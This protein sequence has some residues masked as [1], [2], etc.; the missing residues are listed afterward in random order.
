MSGAPIQDYYL[1]LTSQYGTLNCNV[2]SAG[3]YYKVTGLS[4][5]ETYFTTI[6]ASNANGLGTVAS[7]R[8]FQP[9]SPPPRGVSSLSAVAITVSTGAALV[10]W[11]PPIGY[12]PV[13]DATIFWYAIYGYTT[14][15]ALTPVVK[16]TAGGQTQSNYFIP[17]LDSNS[18]YYFTVRAVNCPGWSVPLLTN[19]I[20]WVTVPA[21][22]PTMASGL[23]LWLDASDATTIGLVGGSSSNINTWSD[24][25]SNN[26]AASTPA[27]KPYLNFSNLNSLNTI[28]TSN[29]SGSPNF[30]YF[31]VNNNY[32]TTFLTYVIVARVYAGGGGSSYGMI[33]TD[34]PGQYGRGIGF[35]GS[36]SSYNYQ[37]LSEN[38]FTTTTAPTPLGSWTVLSIVFNNTTTSPFNVNGSNYS[39]S[40]GNTAPNNTTGLKI[41]IW[42][43]DS[44]ILNTSMEI[45]ETTVYTSA[46][47]PFNTQKVEGYL[48]WKWGL[49]SNLPTIHPF[50]SSRPMSNSV[51]APPML[52][53]LRLWLDASD[54]STLTGLSTVSAWADKSGNSNN[55]SQAV[56]AQQ[57]V[58][59]ITGNGLTGLSFTTP[60]TASGNDAGGQWFRGTFGTTIT[61]NILSVFMVGSMNSGAQN[62][63]R[64]VS[65]SQ[66][67]Q[68]DFVTGG[69]GM[70]IG[71]NGT[72]NAL[73]M[74]A[75]GAY[76]AASAVTL[77]VPFIAETVFDGANQIQVVNGTQTNTR[78]F[79]AN[80]N[81]ARSGIGF[82]A[83]QGVGSTTGRWDG[84]INEV[85]VYNRALSTQDRQTV[86]GY[87]AWKY[88]LQGN[89]PIT[90][91]YKYSNPSIVNFTQISPS[92]FGGLQLWLDASQLT[93]LSNGGALTT[94][95]DRTSNAFVGTAVASPTFI[96]N[97]MNDLPV[98][99]FNGT[100]Q[101][102]NFG[103]N[104]LNIGSNSGVATFAVIKFN[105]T[106]AGGVVG[107]TVY[108]P[109]NARWALRR[110][111]N[112]MRFLVDVNGTGTEATYSDTTTTT[113]LAEGVW[114]R[115]Q[116]FIYKNG[117]L[118]GSNTQAS[119]SNLSNSAPLWVG[120]YPNGSGS[121][122]QAGLFMNG[123]V[124]EI[125]VYMSNITPFIRQ[126]IEGYLSWKWGLQAS[127]PT[128]HPY[129]TAPP[130][131]AYTTFN[132]LLLPNLQLWLDASDT[133]T[134]SFSSGSNIS[135]WRDKSGRSNNA[136][137]TAGTVRLAND[138]NYTAVV[139]TTNATAPNSNY[140]TTSVSSLYTGT[141]TICVAVLRTSSTAF[142][143]AM[144][145]G[146]R[147]ITYLLNTAIM[148]IQGGPSPAASD[149]GGQLGGNS[150]NVNGSRNAMTTTTLTS[151]HIVSFTFVPDATTMSIGANTNGGSPF[152][153]Y[154]AE[155]I[156]FNPNTNS[157]TPYT[158]QRQTVEGYLA[159]KWGLQGLLPATHPY[160]SVNPGA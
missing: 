123:D 13:P 114:N 14:A 19:T 81:I 11:T 157:G 33:A 6:A 132:P 84:T 28:N 32:N 15:N 5:A 29:F 50:R 139:D 110:E 87:L 16:Y 100:S 97:S 65:L 48:A 120:A 96:T 4:N 8:E 3:T 133:T 102:I 151:Y 49:Q 24:K 125:L 101:Y 127:L 150:Y 57:P 73:M 71:R 51:F 46:L 89:L 137:L 77:G 35:T 140:L 9:G 147:R 105:N 41:G 12:P 131:Q 44:A 158:E 91:P 75:N 63:G 67:T 37:I 122:P 115:Q 118:L 80:F 47:T 26:S 53:S 18:N 107:K 56:S 117:A 138:G 126:Q 116:V 86:E 149:D 154:F 129:F 103:S 78:A 21:F 155:I 109:S 10:S 68:N 156:V 159:W 59:Y 40:V 99:R 36:G 90:H 141:L 121:A 20:T 52:S 135:Q 38:Q 112:S 124:A 60:A 94:W 74:E 1:T 153:G 55:V 85:L 142:Q 70:N 119:T 92:T 111:T 108:G 146:G 23:D 134:F 64:A 152:R 98:V 43:P 93:G 2:G 27:I 62:F 42:N 143:M 7:F 76:T 104:I 61:N 95:T 39:V 83:Y 22:A 106:G 160:A 17:Y 72:T 30:D 128:S 148:T 136:N 25:T 145:A 66:L 79:T 69:G 130:Q 31:L 144:G 45:A 54:V 34:T 88:G 113:Q 58:R 82:Q